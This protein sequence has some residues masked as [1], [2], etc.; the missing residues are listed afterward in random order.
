MGVSVKHA[1]WVYNHVPNRLSS[2]TPLELLTKTKADHRDF[3]RSHVW[4]CPVFVLDPKLQDGKKI[5]KWNHGCRLGQFLGFSDEHSSLVANVQNLSTGFVSPQDHVVF[6]DMFQTVY[7]SG[8]NDVV[9]DEICNNLFEFN[10]DVFAED[11]F[12]C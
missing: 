2:L 1:A 4:G 3:L 7:S 12:D 5:P 10:Q 9:V 6:D 8:D 11:E